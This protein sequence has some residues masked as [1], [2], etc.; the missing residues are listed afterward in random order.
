MLNVNIY[1]YANL[2]ALANF[3]YGLHISAICHFRGEKSIQNKIKMVT[4]EVLCFS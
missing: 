1:N 3:R 4:A 2:I